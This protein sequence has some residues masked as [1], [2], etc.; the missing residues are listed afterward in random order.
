MEKKV[1][2]SGQR[3]RT[4]RRRKKKKM[5]KNKL[6]R[7]FNTNICTS[8]GGKLIT[9]LHRDCNLFIE[10]V[11]KLKIHKYLFNIIHRYSNYSCD[12]KI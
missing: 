4:I 12:P 7:P 1:E 3:R 5:K 10:N 8:C 9:F 6:F 11:L 2:I